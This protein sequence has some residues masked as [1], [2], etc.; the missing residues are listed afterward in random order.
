MTPVSASPRSA[1]SPGAA[2]A[3]VQS[4]PSQCTPSDKPSRYSPAGALADDA[5]WSVMRVAARL[6]AIA[7]AG[8]IPAGVA[9][10][11]S[12]AASAPPKAPAG[13]NVQAAAQRAAPAPAAPTPPAAPAPAPPP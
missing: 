7:V 1:G 11:C 13:V 10:A 2:T 4:R 5:D 3:T 6:T 8:S 9:G 12:A